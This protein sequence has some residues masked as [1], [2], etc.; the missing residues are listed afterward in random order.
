MKTIG[1]ATRIAFLVP[2]LASW[3]C[4]AEPLSLSPLQA[5]A[6]LADRLIDGTR[7]LSKGV[8][9]YLMKCVGSKEVELARPAGDEVEYV[10]TAI[11]KACDGVRIQPEYVSY[12]IIAPYFVVK[13]RTFRPPANSSHWCLSRR[14]VV[15]DNFVENGGCKESCDTKWNGEDGR[16]TILN[17][18]SIWKTEMIGADLHA[19]GFETAVSKSGGI[20]ANVTI[21]FPSD[22]V[23]SKDNC[24]ANCK[25]VKFSLN[26]EKWKKVS[27][28]PER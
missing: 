8:R 10:A 7:T 27:T 25:V 19:D 21:V 4:A 18:I 11:E 15:D 24:V 26:K 6:Q 9:L 12:A 1:L 2:L 14:C 23:P 28:A 16:T 20:S 13:G 17:E 22:L 3:S 5:N